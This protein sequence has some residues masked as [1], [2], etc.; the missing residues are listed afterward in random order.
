[1]QETSDR[2]GDRT[3]GDVRE[4]L[5]SERRQNIENMASSLSSEIGESISK[6]N[7]NDFMREIEDLVDDWPVI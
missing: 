2:L 5:Q 1:M 6:R 3:P 7:V 4:S